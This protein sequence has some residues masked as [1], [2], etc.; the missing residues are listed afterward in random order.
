MEEEMRK[1][2]MSEFFCLRGLFLL[3]LCFGA[4]CVMEPIEDDEV[5]E[6]QQTASE[7]QEL[8]A[9][10]ESGEVELLGAG[11]TLMRPFGWNVGGRN[12]VENQNLDEP[13]QMSDGETYYAQADPSPVL[14]SGEATVTC[15]DGLLVVGPKTCWPGGSIP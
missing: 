3:P 7:A 9:A 15:D 6:E 8:A 2:T 1:R 10:D 5:L 11:C 14:G 4:A 12:C 13:V